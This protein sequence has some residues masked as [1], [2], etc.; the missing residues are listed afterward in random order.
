M[1]LAEILADLWRLARRPATLACVVGFIVWWLSYLWLRFAVVGEPEADWA[2]EDRA[3]LALVVGVTQASMVRHFGREA[4][5]LGRPLVLRWLA[6]TGFMVA[7]L[8]AVA[9]GA[10]LFAYLAMRELVEGSAWQQPVEATVTMT[11]LFPLTVWQAALIANV[12]RI[13]AKR[14]WTATAGVRLTV[15]AIAFAAYLLLFVTQPWLDSAVPAELPG[16]AYWVWSV[17]V[18]VP[19]AVSYVFMGLLALAVLLA[20]HRKTVG[21]DTVFD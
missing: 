12:D 13:G 1:T 3:V 7:A 18:L 5:P 11:V 9:L 17:V 16:A 10:N 21:E 8:Y 19:G 6:L 20:V 15:L 14:L 2:I 4:M